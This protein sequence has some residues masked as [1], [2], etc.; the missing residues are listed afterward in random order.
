MTGIRST[1]FLLCL[2]IAGC[3]LEKRPDPSPYSIAQYFKPQLQQRDE[4]FNL[5]LNSM[6]SNWKDC[7][8]SSYRDCNSGRR[9]R[10]QSE[11]EAMRRGGEAA[12]AIM[13][14][15]SE[16]E[17]HCNRPA[18]AQELDEIASR[19]ARL[20]SPPPDAR[21]L[22]MRKQVRR[23]IASGALGVDCAAA[24]RMHRQEIID[25]QPPPRNPR[26]DMP[27][28]EVQCGKP[29]WGVKVGP[30]VPEGMENLKGRVRFRFDIA[31]KSGEQENIRVVSSDLPAEY[32]ASVTVAFRKFRYMP[33]SDNGRPMRQRDCEDEVIVGDPRPWNQ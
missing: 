27:P 18:A 16:I 23:D 20:L 17:N 25:R 3:A 28:G 30:R 12:I 19:L 1:F 14:G 22:A 29:R 2:G 15:E 11:Q 5:L 9:E 31:A 33:F 13:A 24:E 21:S 8:E 32:V 6:E 4:S 26:E 7:E 10:E